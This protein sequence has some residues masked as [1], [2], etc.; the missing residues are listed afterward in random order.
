MGVDNRQVG[1]GGVLLD[2]VNNTNLE[3]CHIGGYVKQT[4]LDALHVAGGVV[5]A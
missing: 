1:Q 3:A 5:D 4:N 2:V